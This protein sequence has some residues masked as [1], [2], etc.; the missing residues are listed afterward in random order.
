VLEIHRPFV[1]GC[2]TTAKLREGA[3]RKRN[4]GITLLGATF[5]GGCSSE[6]SCT[7]E[8]TVTRQC[9]TITY[10]ARITFKRWE[11]PKIPAIA[12]FYT[13]KDIWIDVKRFKISEGISGAHGCA[14]LGSRDA[15][16]DEHDP[17]HIR[18]VDITDTPAADETK[19][20]I[21]RKYTRG[22]MVQLEVGIKTRSHPDGIGSLDFSLET[23]VL[24]EYDL[25]Y[26]LEPGSVYAFRRR[27]SES[28]VI[29]CAARTPL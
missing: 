12:P 28:A 20:G 5:S 7:V 13:V 10:P 19:L 24:V 18:T 1:D 3:S 22:K 6:A 25:S 26:S 9:T 15:P 14:L 4:V 2:A 27:S 21:E 23:S 17:N 16:P 11:Y 8:H 29:W